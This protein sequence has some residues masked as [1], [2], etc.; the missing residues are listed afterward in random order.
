MHEMLLIGSQSPIELDMT[1]ISKRFNLNG[2]KY[3]PHGC[4]YWLP[5]G[6]TGNLGYR[7]ERP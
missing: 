6:S 1:Q 4:R 2:V 3:K 5:G 7:K